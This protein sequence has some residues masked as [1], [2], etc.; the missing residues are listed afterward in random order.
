M[1]ILGTVIVVGRPMLMLETP[2][3]W[4]WHHK[5]HW[6]GTPT[7]TALNP[8]LDNELLDHYS[9]IVRIAKLL[10]N[11]KQKVKLVEKKTMGDI[12]SNTMERIQHEIQSAE[13]QVRGEK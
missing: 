12:L 8:D 6:Q 5:V 9:G 3:S 1:A 13:E 4:S 7:S 10:Q 11:F 2:Y